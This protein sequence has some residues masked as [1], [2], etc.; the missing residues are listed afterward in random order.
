MRQFLSTLGLQHLDML[1]LK[2]RKERSG[3]DPKVELDE[4]IDFRTAKEVKDG[5]GGSDRKRV[6]A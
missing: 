3:G 2:G 1:N 5:Y 4:E 6:G